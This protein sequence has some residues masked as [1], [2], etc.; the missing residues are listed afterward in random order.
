[1]T[2]G[3]AIAVEEVA[4]V[5]VVVEGIAEDEADEAGATDQTID[6]ENLQRARKTDQKHSSSNAGIIMPIC[7]YDRN[8]SLP[9][10]I[11]LVHR[12]GLDPGS[13]ILPFS[14]YRRGSC[15]SAQ[16]TA[17]FARPPLRTMLLRYQ[18]V[19]SL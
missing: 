14:L 9:I 10:I 1:M 13:S 16:I 12:S 5:V 11:F 4:V 7:L 6:C 3:T 8:G 19:G 2:V 15:R 17:G 18:V